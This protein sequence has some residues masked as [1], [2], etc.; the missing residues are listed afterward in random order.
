[1]TTSFNSLGALH[2]FIREGRS[3]MLDYG[4]PRVA[5]TVLTDR[6]IRVRLGPD[7]TFMA[8]RSWA[9][10][11]VD[12]EFGEVTFEV[13]ES[14]RELLL[15]TATLTV[16]I[17]RGRGRLSF[18][19]VQGQPFCADE[20]GMQWDRSEAEPRRVTCAK[21]IEDGEHFFGFGER[22][23][24]LDKL[25]RQMINWTTDPPH[26]HGPGTDPIYEAI[27]VFMALRPHLAYGVFFNNTW[28]SRFDMGAEQSDVWRMEADGGELDY[29]VVYGPTPE[30][31]S[32]GMGVL[33]GTMPLP[34]RWALGYHHSRWGHATES[35]VRGLTAEFRKRDIPCDVIHLDID[36]MDGYRVFT[37][38]LQSFPD[39]QALVGDLRRNGFR[40]VTIID[41]GVKSDPDY[42]VY[43]SGLEHDVFIRRSDGTV[44]HGYVWPDDSVFADY[45]RPEV[46]KWWGEMQKALIDVG[47][48]GIWNDMNEPTSFELPFSEG[49][50][51]VGTIPLDAIQGP[52]GERTIHAEV[53]N[54]YG[55]GMSRA[56]YE[57]LRRYLNNE[58]PFVLTR[59]GFAGVQNWSACWM[60]DNHS[61]W[62]HLEM[63]M[64]QL[65]NMG[66][67]GVPFVGTDIGGFAGNASGELFARWMQFGVCSPFCRAHSAIDTERHEPWVFGPRVEAICR[68]FLQLR[69]R[70]LP[71]IYSLFWEA[72]R[73]GIPVLRPLLYQFPDDPATYPLHDQVLLGSQIMAAPIYHPG[74][75]HRHVYLPEGEWYDWWTEEKLAGPAHLLAYAPLERMPLYVRA[76]A[77][78]PS[79]PNLHYADQY[80]LEPLTLDLYPGNGS[81]T[82][83]EDDGHSFEYEQGQFCTTNYMLRHTGDRLIFEIGAREGAY[84]PPERQLVI[85]V[86]AMAGQA[87]QEYADASYDFARRLLILPVDD[88]GSQRTFSFQLSS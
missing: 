35:M 60:G 34:P 85:K 13:E 18:A 42:K 1:M 48:S 43:Q 44:F 77:I 47:V 84:V 75:E 88:D 78:I 21:H 58:R 14:G 87:A 31:V 40:I 36:Y 73:R 67:S 70:L 8:R 39:P 83:Y 37:W 64:P 79:G 61:W 45:T 3:L 22:T 12:E 30:K 76:G 86:H 23:G 6:I 49:V 28:R 9:V 27:P 65:M 57:G 29:Y 74:R 56:S 71:Y 69:Y 66:L 33:L 24:L 15:R 50:G 20:E 51:E 62:E 4:G 59:S 63:A 17:D 41:P 26:G 72:S 53:H 2:S 82:L 32:E 25:G 68:E 54:L 10:A 80:P 46:R 55:Y 5:I 19:N 16:R 81:F 11:R 38:N 7:G 52:E